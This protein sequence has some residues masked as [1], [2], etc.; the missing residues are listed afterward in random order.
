MNIDVFLSI[1][2]TYM[3]PI[4]FVRYCCTS[5]N[6]YELYKFE[7]IWKYF[8]QKQYPHC[9]FYFN[10]I[11]IC[12]ENSWYDNYKIIHTI[13]HLPI[14]Q[15]S[16][17][18]LSISVMN[19]IVPFRDVITLKSIP[20]NSNEMSSFILGYISSDYN[21]ELFRYIINYT[22]THEQQIA[23]D[24]LITHCSLITNGSCDGY[25]SSDTDIESMKIK[26]FFQIKKYLLTFQPTLYD[27][28]QD[29]QDEFVHYFISLMKK[30]NANGRYTLCENV[31]NVCETNK[32]KIKEKLFELVIMGVLN[33][34]LINM[35]YEDIDDEDF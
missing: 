18:I 27:F 11:E 22:N 7:F 12:G 14:S 32:E 6:N 2:Y 21:Y 16:K 13:S 20:T 24:D 31:L 35:Y 19:H 17:N 33:N 23:F 15:L 9:N 34:N 25:T 8:Y 26:L 28:C 10:N 4:D 29:L 30:E 3:N 1:G 5:K